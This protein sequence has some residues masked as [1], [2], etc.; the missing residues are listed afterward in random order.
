MIHRA[1]ERGT[2][3]RQHGTHLT[4]RG[5]NDNNILDRIRSGQIV[6]PRTKEAAKA[7]YRNRPEVIEAIQALEA[8]KRH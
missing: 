3:L 4:A 7:V 2:T 1:S 8:S 6:D 5:I